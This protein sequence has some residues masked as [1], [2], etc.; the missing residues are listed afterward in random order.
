LCI[1]TKFEREQ[2]EKDFPFLVSHLFRGYA[3]FLLI[4]II[5]SLLFGMGPG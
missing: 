1:Y 5:F 4:L 3:L 2:R